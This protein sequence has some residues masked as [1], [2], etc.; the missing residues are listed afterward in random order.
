MIIKALIARIT[1]RLQTD[2]TGAG[3]P[4]VA[5]G[6]APPPTG[7]GQLPRLVV[8][9]G[10]LEMPPPFGDSP[11]GQVRPRETTEV[12]PV[13]ANAVQGPYTLQQSPLDGT[14]SC[15][16]VWRQRLDPLEGKKTR[17]YPRKGNTGDGFTINPQTR[18]LQLFHS[19]A[20][21]GTPELEVEYAYAAVFTLREF[22]QM[23]LLE[24]YANNLAD[25]EKWAALATAVLL[26]NTAKLLEDSNKSGN[27]HSSGNYTTTHLLSEVQWVEGLPERI[28]DNIFR[29]TA[30]FRCSG[31]IILART[32][33]ESAAAIQKIYSP[34]HKSDPGP[35]SIE[36]N[37]D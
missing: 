25:A 23:L 34:G 12:F 4:T 37:L 3:A 13:N 32:L 19:Q 7:Q 9:A 29:H 35:I 15:R 30:Q 36:A 18:Q 14:L 1:T 16:L 8:S 20:L 27:V 6:P 28:A 5:E 2:L 22:R 26:T 10:K 24:A 33:S 31:Q 11:P 21:S 17:L